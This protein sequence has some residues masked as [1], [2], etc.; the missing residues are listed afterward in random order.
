M[1]MEESIALLIFYRAE[2]LNYLEDKKDITSLPQWSSFIK[3]LYS[4]ILNG[5][6]K[7]GNIEFNVPL[8]KVQLYKIRKNISEE[9]LI[10]LRKIEGTSLDIDI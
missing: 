5:K 4:S 9:E 3:K 6:Y 8:S 2:G 7:V 1:I 10:F